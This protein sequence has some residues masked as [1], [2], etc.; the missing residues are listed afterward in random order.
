MIMG[1]DY[2]RFAGNRERERWSRRKSREGETV[3]RGEEERNGEEDRARPNIMRRPT[4]TIRRNFLGNILYFR[5]NFLG[6]L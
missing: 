3:R 1:E 6:I 5:R 4:E 2:G